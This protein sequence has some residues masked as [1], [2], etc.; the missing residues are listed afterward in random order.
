MKGKRG[1]GWEKNAKKQRYGNHIDK[2]QILSYYYNDAGDLITQ[3]F[4]VFFFLLHLNKVFKQIHRFFGREPYCSS[5]VP[6]DGTQNSSYRIWKGTI[7]AR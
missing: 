1:N 5:D 6:S 2:S 7:F 3:P 4:T